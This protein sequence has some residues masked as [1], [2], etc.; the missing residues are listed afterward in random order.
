MCNI[1]LSKSKYCKAVQC[2]KILWLDKYKPEEAIEKARDSVLENG[3]KVG[4]LARQYFGEYI[5]IN[6][7]ENL[8][9]M[10]ENTKANLQNK[11]NIITE[12]SFNFNNNFCSVD[13]L[14]N[15]IDGFEIYEVKS[16]TEVKAIYL[17]DVSYQVYVLQNLGY[18]IKK[19]SI[20]YIN[21]RYI[22]NG[23]LN[24]K[25]L[26]NIDDVTDIAFSK[27][28]EI[29]EKIE[30]VNDYIK[31]TDEPEEKISMKCFKPYECSYWEYCT[32]K[33]PEKNVFTIKGGM[34]TDKKFELYN[35]GIITYEDI[36]T[37]NINEKYKQQAEIDLSN[38]IVI[39]KDEIREFMK[40]LSYPIYF[41]DF[42]TYQAAV[43]EYDG[44]WPYEQ[45]PFQYS[46]HYVEKEGGELKHKEFLAEAGIDPR[47]ILAERLVQDIPMNVCVT[48]YNMG[49]EK[50]R[51]KEMA[52]LFGDLREH[53]MNIHD[54]IK[55]LMIPFHDRWYYTKDMKGS[56][57][58]KY[59]LPA[60]F[61]NDPELDYHNLPVVHNGGEASQAFTDL[62]NH[63]KE[64]QEEIRN[65]LLLYCGLDTLAMVKVWEKLKE[66]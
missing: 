15:D 55:D 13:I 21:N 66:V 34:H 47:R 33:L 64:E 29:K 35:E 24:L 1:C 65:G 22:K 36:L 16:S 7:D 8:A 54:N 59:V 42:E 9:N 40:T 44:T 57:S 32:K 10:I 20:M 56:Y 49:F 4:E 28:E 38:E 58:I 37:T 41:L 17:D 53:L 62:I 63:T 43:P 3:T 39:K 11:P 26:F 18:K 14:K 50:G 6:F 45:I 23:E 31:T 46:L 60:L 5:N 27:Q 61:P 2:N 25:K 12:A 48:A 30:E 19:A 52:G 51:I